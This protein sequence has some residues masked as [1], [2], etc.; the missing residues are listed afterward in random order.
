MSFFKKNKD[1]QLYTG[2]FLHHIEKNV[3]ILAQNIMASL[4]FLPWKFKR[5]I[6][7]FTE[8]LEKI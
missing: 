1:V 8:K 4:Q 5:N 6:F 3:N 2:L 7:K